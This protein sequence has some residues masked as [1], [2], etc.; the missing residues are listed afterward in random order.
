MFALLYD[1]VVENNFGK[2]ESISMNRKIVNDFKTIYIS[3]KKNKK[4]CLYEYF[5]TVLEFYA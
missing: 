4:T 2:F 3:K 1:V 5:S